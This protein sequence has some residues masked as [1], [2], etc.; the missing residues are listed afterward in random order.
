MKLTDIKV[1][2]YIDKGPIFKVGDYVKI[3]RYENILQ[4]TTL[5]IGL[6]ESL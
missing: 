2:I 4:K 5:Q 6:R 3:S 1:N